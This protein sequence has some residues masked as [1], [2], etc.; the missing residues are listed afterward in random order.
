MFIGKIDHYNLDVKP[1]LLTGP[2]GE[3]EPAVVLHAQGKVYA[4]LPAAV[5]LRIATSIA[6]SLAAHHG[7]KA[8]P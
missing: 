5:A 2:D 1:A 6:D 8:T 7:K 3:R 4:V